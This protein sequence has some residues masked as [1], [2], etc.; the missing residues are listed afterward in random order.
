MHTV[1][2]LVAGVTMVMALLATASPGLGQP[3]APFAFFAGLSSS[4]YPDVEGK[5][6][7]VGRQFRLHPTVAFAVG[8]TQPDVLRY[9]PY[10]FHD[11]RYSNDDF[12]KNIVPVHLTPDG[13]D[14]M[15]S[16][17]SLLPSITDGGLDSGHILSFALYYDGAG[18][19]QVFDTILGE[20]NA[21]AL[22]NGLR[23]AW[24][25]QPEAIGPLTA[26][27]C[28]MGLL[29]GEPPLEMTALAQVT[30][31]ELRLEPGTGLFVTT[32]SIKNVSGSSFVP[33]VSLVVNT[34]SG[35]V[36]LD[37]ATGRTCKI[38][39]GGQD[40]MNL[41]GSLAHNATVSVTVK[42]RN[43]AMTRFPLTTRIFAGSGE[44]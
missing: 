16:R 2:G 5:L 23:L 10:R 13:V 9:R 26:L 12:A 11:I 42:F 28:G 3:N 41:P 25:D 20:A 1:V 17:L 38:E 19:P 31:G 32:I 35:D 30:V 34:R 22:I 4:Q 18:G 15:L 43:P 36:R 40:F 6:T 14:S 29:S 8:G 39:P 7:Y 24:D 33:P 21:V 44:R 37:N 27:G